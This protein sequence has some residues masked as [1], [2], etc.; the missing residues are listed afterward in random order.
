VIG[1]TSPLFTV[2]DHAVSIRDAI[3][4]GGGLFLLTKKPPV[5]FMKASKAKV[6]LDPKKGSMPPLA[7]SLCR[8]LC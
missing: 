6:M 3:L 8:S 2:F 4:I 5:K 7:P 1:L